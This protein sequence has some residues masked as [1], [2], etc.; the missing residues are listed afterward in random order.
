MQVKSGMESGNRSITQLLD[1]WR[2]GESDE[3]LMQAV[4]GG[5]SR[6]ASRLLRGERAGHTLQTQALVHEA[7]LRLVDQRHIHWKNRAHFF[8]IA[9]RMMRRILVD[10]ARSR[11]AGNRRGGVARISVDDLPPVV[12]ERYPEYLALDDALTR[13][14]AGNPQ[15][16]RLVELRYFGGLT[17][18]EI[19]ELLDVSVPTVARRWRVARAWLYREMDHQR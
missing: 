6:R 18:A 5:L 7:Y 1:G 10:R 14:E 8:A 12:S 16:A 4:Y 2:Q 11:L 3:E 19:A 13:L 9:A 17:R 15:L